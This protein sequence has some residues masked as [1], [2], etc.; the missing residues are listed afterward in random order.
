MSNLKELGFE[1][2]YV[3]V[4]R[5]DVKN[6]M[7]VNPKRADE[8]LLA[9]DEINCHRWGKGKKDNNYLVVNTDETYAKE[10]AGIIKK[11]ENIK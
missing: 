1:D 3:V 8:F 11:Y 10:V 4:K 2:K 7:E 6:L 9:L 5:E